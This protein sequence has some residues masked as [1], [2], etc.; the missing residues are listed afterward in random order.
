MKLEKTLKDIKE[1]KIQ[2]AISIALAAVEALEDL[3]KNSKGVLLTNLNRRSNFIPQHTSFIR[4][5]GTFWEHMC[6]KKGRT[7]PLNGYGLTFHT[8]NTSRMNR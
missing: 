3:I 1:M 2:G 7:S 8:L 4:H 5:C 6:S